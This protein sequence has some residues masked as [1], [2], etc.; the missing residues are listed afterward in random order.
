MGSTLLELPDPLE[1]KVS[2]IAALWLA[3]LALCLAGCVRLSHFYCEKALCKND[4]ALCM[5]LQTNTNWK[6]K[7]QT[8]CCKLVQGTNWREMVKLALL[9][10]AWC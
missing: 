4:E 6:K 1:A 2:I 5:N 3:L 7:P 9:F 8:Y 10:S